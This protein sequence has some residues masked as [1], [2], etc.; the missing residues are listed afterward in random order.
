MKWRQKVGIGPLG[1]RGQ[2][3]C[4]GLKYKTSHICQ[5]YDNVDAEDHAN[6]V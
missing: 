4:T 6:A 5:Q 1:T 2:K 3:L